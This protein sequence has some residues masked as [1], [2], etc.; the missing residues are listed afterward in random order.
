MFTAVA[1]TNDTKTLYTLHS[2]P[3]CETAAQLTE[4][5]RSEDKI[6]FWREI[7]KITLRNMYVFVHH[8]SQQYKNHNS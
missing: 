4:V 5:R 6:F 3:E 8:N 1:H 7:P 2:I